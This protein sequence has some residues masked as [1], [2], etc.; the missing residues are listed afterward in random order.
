M[1]T[2]LADA[3][4]LT[5]GTDDWKCQMTKHAAVHQ[6]LGSIMLEALVNCD[7]ELILD[8]LMDVQPV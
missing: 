1:T 6:V 7:S 5:T 3:S 2:E 8:T 4:W